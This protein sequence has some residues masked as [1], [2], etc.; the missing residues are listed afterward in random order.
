[1]DVLSV[2]MRWLHLLGAAVAVGGFIYAAK[3]VAPAME[4]LSTDAKAKLAAGFAARLRP[5][6]FTVIGLM[7]V[8]GIYNIMMHVAGKPVAYHIVLTLKLV[9]ALHVLSML[10]LLSVPPGANPARDA[11]R[12]RLMAGAAG[13]GAMVLLL[14]AVLTLGF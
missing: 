11:R 13:S 12:P 10:F 3:V 5:L 4:G 14:S 6:A 9:L 1:M 8:T 7:L 2:L